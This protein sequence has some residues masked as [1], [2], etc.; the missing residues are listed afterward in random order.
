MSG[1]YL[2]AAAYARRRYGAQIWMERGSRHILSQAKIM[3][4]LDLQGPSEFIIERELEGYETCDRLV[5]PL[6]PRRRKFPTR[7]FSAS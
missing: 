6:H 3:A 4:D 1:M 2:E 7:K 5:I